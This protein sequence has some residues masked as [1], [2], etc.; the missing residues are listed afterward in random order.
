MVF[1]WAAWC[2]QVAEEAAMVRCILSVERVAGHLI[3]QADV[4]LLCITGQ[5]SATS[6][7]FGTQDW[8]C[9]CYYLHEL[10]VML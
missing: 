7:R 5:S 8:A 6:A 1:S 3:E 4:A 10:P 9:G 2:L